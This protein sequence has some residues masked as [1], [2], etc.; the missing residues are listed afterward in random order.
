ME[1]TAM[2]RAQI[3][4]RRR[5][6]WGAA[7]ASLTAIVLSWWVL[8]AVVTVQTLPAPLAS[9]STAKTELAVAQSARVDL[10]GL[11][12]LPI[13]VE[14]AAFDE[15]QRGFRES[16]E[17]A[18]EHA[19]TAYAWIEVSHRQ[20]VRVVAIDGEAVEVELLEGRHAGR[21]GWLKTRQLSP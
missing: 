3:V 5:R 8:I 11:S 17:D 18:I 19:F 20:A 1:W 10:P 4:G 12:S 6:G 13:P 7:I 14:R 15:A 16:D 9:A 2:A 21:H